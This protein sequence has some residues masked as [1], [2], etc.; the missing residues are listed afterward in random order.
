VPTRTGEGP[1]RTLMPEWVSKKYASMSAID[2]SFSRNRTGPPG[3]PSGASAPHHRVCKIACEALPTRHG[4]RAILRTRSVSHA[5]I[6]RCRDIGIQTSTDVLIHG[7]ACRPA[8]SG[9]KPIREPDSVRKIAL[10][11]CLVVAPRRRFCTP[12]YGAFI[13]KHF[14]KLALACFSSLP[15]LL[16]FLPCFSSFLASLPSLLLFLPCLLRPTTSMRRTRPPL[17]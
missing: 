13:V 14:L 1:N 10:T 12:L 11:P 7:C 15:S 17:S 9:S 4:I 8:A 3:C 2:D 6:R 5:I 16:L